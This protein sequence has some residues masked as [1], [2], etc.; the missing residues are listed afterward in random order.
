MELMPDRCQ[1]F[2]ETG[3][4]GAKIFQIDQFNP[5][6]LERGRID[7]GAL[8]E[9]FER[10]DLFQPGEFGAGQHG[11]GPGAEIQE[12]GDLAGSP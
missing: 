10:D 6:L 8:E 2:I 7:F 5:G 3:N 11:G 9:L 1:D 12:C 4:A